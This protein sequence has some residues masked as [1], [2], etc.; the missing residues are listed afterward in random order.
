MRC[1]SAGKNRSTANDCQ[2]RRH[3]RF[4]SRHAGDFAK[5]FAERIK[6][7]G[8]GVRFHLQGFMIGDGGEESGQGKLWFYRR[9]QEQAQ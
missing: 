6:G 8:W 4:V 5:K 7:V 2:K 3:P 1:S 9:D